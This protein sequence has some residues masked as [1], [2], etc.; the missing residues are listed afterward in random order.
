MNAL[1]AEVF[2]RIRDAIL[3]LERNPRPQGCKKLKGGDAY[4]LR[5]G[6][7]RVLYTIDD[8]QHVVEVFAV[9]HRRDVYR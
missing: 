4:R 1:P 8:R 6:T 7:Y 5:V 9:G 3:R 2:G